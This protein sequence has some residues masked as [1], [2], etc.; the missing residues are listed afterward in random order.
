MSLATRCPDC[1]TLFK[2]S[3]GQLQTHG[4]QV[5]CGHC[6]HVFSGVD[7]LTAADA[8]AWLGLQTALHTPSPVD[9]TFGNLPKTDADA[10]ATAFLNPASAARKPLWPSLQRRVQAVQAPWHAPSHYLV[11]YGLLSALLVIQIVV[12]SR[13]WI[14]S[15]LPPLA[16]WVSHSSPS[17]QWWAA[18]PASQALNVEGSGLSRL[19][20]QQ[21]QLDIT[22]QNTSNLPSRWPH[23]QVSL[24]DSQNQVLAAQVLSPSQYL[25][26]Q[27]TPEQLKTPFPAQHTAELQAFINTAD[28]R[29]QLPGTQAVGFK[30][31]LVDSYTPTSN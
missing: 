10:N 7:H 11:I 6:H 16:N 30:L 5:R 27:N 8:D 17:L 24:T 15:G 9:A 31:R 2:V 29:L 3:L 28:L 23:L 13:G 4:G 26:I 22:L 12:A 14:L 20:D 21:L 19:S 18:R 25:R 1:K